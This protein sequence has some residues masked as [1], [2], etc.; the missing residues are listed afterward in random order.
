MIEKREATVKQILYDDE[1]TT[2]LMVEIENRLYKAYNYK[3]ITGTVCEGDKVIINTGAVSLN[4]GTGGYHFVIH[5]KK[6]GSQDFTINEGHIIKLRYTPIQVKCNTVEESDSPY[7]QIICDTE[8]IDGMFV[9]IGS[10]HSMLSPVIH[11]LRY[12]HSD[13]NISYIMTDSA[14]LPLSFS[15]TVKMLKEQ[16]LLQNTI[17]CGQ[18]FGGDFETVNIYTA[19]I[20]SKRVCKSDVA[21]IMPGPGVVGTSTPLGFSNIEEGHL[22]DAVNTL[23]GIPIVIPRI[24]FA[25]VR[26]RHIGISHHTLTIL[27]RIAYSAAHVTFPILE[28]SK[29]KILYDQILS[30]SIN[31]KHNVCYVQEKTISILR[32]NNANVMTMGRSVNTDPEFFR[33]IGAAAT[34]CATGLKIM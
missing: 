6:Q 16:R 3:A 17:T 20:T 26:K 2:E 19:L 29:H 34:L 28:R 22:I 24:S 10:L 25:D 1:D 31:K 27:S 14:C 9:L 30:N 15:K 18:A 8:N 5:N 4:L 33:A 32:D 23:K 13:L 21:I 12:Y 11:V 7:H